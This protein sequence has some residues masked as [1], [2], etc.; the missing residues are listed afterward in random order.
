M[1]CLRAVPL[2]TPPPSSAENSPSACMDMAQDNHS[3]DH[4]PDLEYDLLT[5]PSAEEDEDCEQQQLPPTDYDSSSLLDQLSCQCQC[6]TPSSLPSLPQRSHSSGPKKF[7]GFS[8]K[9]CVWFT[10]GHDEYDRAT[11]DIVK[12]TYKDMLEFLT[13]RVE[14][15]D[16]ALKLAQGSALL[17]VPS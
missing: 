12:L 5:C 4:L 13:F 1:P 16:E 2:S 15:R 10:H 6:R 17:T 7:V 9:V 3:L 14:M 8:D 11:D